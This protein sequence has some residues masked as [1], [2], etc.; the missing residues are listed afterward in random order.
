[1]KEN[2]GPLE[3]L[4]MLTLGRK[5]LRYTIDVPG[6]YSFALHLTWVVGL[7]YE[8]DICLYLFEVEV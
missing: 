2:N 3:F 5:S 4:I 8:V 7:I 1:M 6:S